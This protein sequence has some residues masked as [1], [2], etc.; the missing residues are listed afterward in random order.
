MQAAGAISKPSHA[1]SAGLAFLFLPLDGRRQTACFT[2]SSPTPANHQQDSMISRTLGGGAPGKGHRPDPGVLRCSVSRERSYQALCGLFFKP[3]DTR[4]SSLSD[5]SRPSVEQFLLLLST[6]L[7]PVVGSSSRAYDLYPC[8]FR[9]QKLQLQGCNLVRTLKVCQ[10]VNNVQGSCFK[11]F[12]IHLRVALLAVA[13]QIQ[14]NSRI[15]SKQSLR[16]RWL[17]LQRPHRSTLN[18]K[19]VESV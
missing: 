3:H 19:I 11:C 9:F 18:L 17:C 7:I 10:S 5:P 12:K 4:E 1:A 13:R 16:W 15:A 14:R 2:F 6:T 8:P